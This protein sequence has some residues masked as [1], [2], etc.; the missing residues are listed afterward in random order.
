MTHYSGKERSEMLA[1]LE[2]FFVTSIIEA[3]EAS[4]YAFSVSD[5][6][7][8]EKRDLILSEQARQQGLELGG[9]GSIAVGTLFA[10][11]YSVWVMAVISACSL[12]DTLLNTGEDVIRFE[13]NGTGGMRYETRVERRLHPGLELKSGGDMGS[14]GHFLVQRSTEIRWIR[15]RL[16]QHLIRIFQS[17]AAATG[18][19]IRVMNALVAH[20]VQQLILRM[21]G[22]QAIWKTDERLALIHHDAGVWLAPT[23]EN[24]FAARLQCFEHPEWQGPTFLIR[25]YCC[26]AYQVGKGDSAAHGYCSSCPK[27]DTAER[28]RMLLK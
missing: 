11:R 22:D 20:N 23:K 4:E 16:Q 5:L 21:T 25:P 7:H 17:A 3:D 1:V 26:L 13:L 14:S 8:E 9:A 27:L 2:S 28:L 10:K 12:Y 6:L 19:N 15:D 24:S 18:A